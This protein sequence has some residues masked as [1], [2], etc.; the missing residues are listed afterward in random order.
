MFNRFFTRLSFAT[1]YRT[2]IILFSSFLLTNCGFPGKNLNQ[3]EKSAEIEWVFGVFERNYAPEV[4]KSEK[5][6]AGIA[7]I[8]ADC[9]EKSKTIEKGDEFIGLLNL[10]VNRFQDAHTR[11]IAGGQTLPEMINVAYLGFNTELIRF[12]LSAPPD[13]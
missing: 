8:K 6:G 11:I 3:V 10:C 7:E 5:H 12:D 4:W 9:I 1:L 2:L 13:N